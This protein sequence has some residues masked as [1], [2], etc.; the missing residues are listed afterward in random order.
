[1]INI[2]DKKDCCGCEACVQRCPRHCIS[3]HEDEEGFLYPRVDASAC[4][5]CGLCERVCPVLNRGVEHEPF[6]SYAAKNRN[7][8]IRMT[9]SSGG[10]FSAL[11]EGTLSEGGVVFGAMFDSEWN[12]VHGYVEGKEELRRLRGS[13]YV[14]SHIVCSYKQ[15][16]EFLKQGRKVL[17]SGTPCQIAGL[18]HFLRKEYD[19]L[20]LVD[21]I[22]HGVPSPGVWRRYL[23]EE[24]ALK[25]DPKNT[26]LPR[27]IRG[28]DAHVE[29]ISF[30]DKTLGWK[31]F[32]FSLVLSTTNG[33][34][35]KFSFCS[36]SHLYENPFMK[37]FLA[38][39]Y[40]RP[41][42]YYC[43]VKCGR[44]GSDITLGDF[45]GVDG[46]M[47]ELDD[48]RGVSAVLVN[49]PHGAEALKKSGVSLWPVEYSQILRRNP[50]LVRSVA[51]PYKKRV[52]FFASR[53]RSFHKTI[54]KLTRKPLKVRVKN[55]IGQFAYALLGQKV[56]KALKRLL[57]KL[58]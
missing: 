9:S 18:R 54:T 20:L 34:G 26:V 2:V 17:F 4:I 56:G 23:K 48:D 39:I 37:G 47:P 19:N 33:S 27:P 11:A 7:D 30:R 46:V 53:Q 24:V 15:T 55:R 22:C 35:E 14:Q 50:A 51:E 44:S 13:K 3:L 32:S 1:M 58:I 28:R 49:T 40:L 29:D 25:C 45:W 41:S 8:E 57:S 52:K 21:V 12:V 31:K 16:E 36:R 6:A 10:I 5:D 42:C 38:D 43:P